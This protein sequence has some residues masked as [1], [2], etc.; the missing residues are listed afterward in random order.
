MEILKKILYPFAALVLFF[1]LIIGGFWAYYE[2]TKPP[3]QNLKE[4]WVTSQ[5]WDC[6]PD[7]SI[8]A[9]LNSNIYHEPEDPYYDRTDAANGRCFDTAAHAEA[10]GFRASAGTPDRQS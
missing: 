7:Y 3:T 8:K 9:N 6:P 2:I 4:G 5:T 10:Q 1:A